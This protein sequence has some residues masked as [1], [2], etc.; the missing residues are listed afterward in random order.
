MV[1]AKSLFD[2]KLYSDYY[3]HDQLTSGK[4]VPAI[5]GMLVLIG[6]GVYYIVMSLTTYAIVMFA[7]ALLLAL[8]YVARVFT[9]IKRN[10]SALKIDNDPYTVLVEVSDKKIHSFDSR[11]GKHITFK[12]AEIKRVCETGKYFYFHINKKQAIVLRKADIL[13]GS[14][15]DI[16][17]WAKE[18]AAARKAAKKK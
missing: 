10:S 7:L 16:A 2:K 15:A 1:T 14:A 4:V 18:A 11:T 6:I 13:E 9:M 5:L 3:W 12:W 17:K 8:S